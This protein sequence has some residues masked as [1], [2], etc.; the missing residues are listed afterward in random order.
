MMIRIMNNQIDQLLVKAG[1]YF[2][3]EGVVYNTFDPK[4]SPS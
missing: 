1:A 2:G 4:S 3:A